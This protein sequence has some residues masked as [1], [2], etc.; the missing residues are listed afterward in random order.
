MLTS[1]PQIS[2]NTLHS[3]IPEVYK[4]HE[5]HEFEA[6]S[7]KYHLEQWVVKKPWKFKLNYQTYDIFINRD[8]ECISKIIDTL[9][10]IF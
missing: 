4:G 3:V 10:F 6:H 1:T 8:I 2:N 5:P 9:I 7:L